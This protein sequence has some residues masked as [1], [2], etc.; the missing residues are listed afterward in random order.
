M[1]FNK[2]FF[3]TTIVV[4]ITILNYSCKKKFDCVCSAATQTNGFNTF[5]DHYT[6]KERNKK[7]AEEACIEKT[8][9]YDN[10]VGTQQSYG[11]VL[12]TN[13]DLK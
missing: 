12:F 7:K 10:L 1:I 13:C 8:K 4:F 5:A 3:R 9:N 2:A 6:V 11:V